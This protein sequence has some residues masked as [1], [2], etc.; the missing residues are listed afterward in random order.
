MLPDNFHEVFLV[1]LGNFLDLDFLL[2]DVVFELG[3]SKFLHF[4]DALGILNFRGLRLGLGLGLGLEQFLEIE[5]ELGD[6][7]GK[8]PGLGR[9]FV[10]GL[11][12]VNSLWGDLEGPLIFVIFKK[13]SRDTSNCKIFYHRC[14]L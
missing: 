2:L 1:L 14:V 5:L 10:L 12:C 3:N 6:F 8:F 9:H 4:A 11:L 7:L 13:Y